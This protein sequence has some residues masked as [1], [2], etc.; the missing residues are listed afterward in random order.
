MCI[1]LSKVLNQDRYVPIKHMLFLSTK[2]S[3]L[4][5]LTASLQR[6]K[7]F[8]GNKRSIFISQMNFK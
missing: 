1:E 5:T 6:E 7:Q 3:K 8:L 2:N 4:H